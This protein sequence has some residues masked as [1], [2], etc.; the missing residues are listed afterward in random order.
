MDI[1]DDTELVEKD[2][3]TDHLVDTLESRQQEAMQSERATILRATLTQ[4]Y[5]LH[6][7]DE[8]G[9]VENLVA[10][11]VGG[12]PS[13]V[14]GVVLGGILWA[15]EEELFGK[16]KAKYGAEVAPVLSSEVVPVLSSV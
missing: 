10:R 11:V 14:G 3:S 2:S 8:I 5:A 13:D 12:P 15:Q 1:K 16:L 4:Y 6:A 7:P 9:K